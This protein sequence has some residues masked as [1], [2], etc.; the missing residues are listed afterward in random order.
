MNLEQVREDNSNTLDEHKADEDVIMNE[1][2]ASS[3]KEQAKGTPEKT[4]Q[5]PFTEADKGKKAQPAANSAQPLPQLMRLFPQRMYR[6]PK[7]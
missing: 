7:Q 1:S 6:S 4:P 3:R 5:K 2:E